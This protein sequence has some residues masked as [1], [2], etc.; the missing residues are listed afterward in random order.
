VLLYQKESGR[1]LE[2]FQ[3]NNAPSELKKVPTPF[4]SCP[5]KVEQT[6][7]HLMIECSLFSKDR[8]AVL[9][10]LPLPLI[11]Q[12]HIHSRRLQI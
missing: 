3:E 5:E 2:I 6:A 7:R 8:P 4:C 1:S 10:N 12:F 9:R 11:L